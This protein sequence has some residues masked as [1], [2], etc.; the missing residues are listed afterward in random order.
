LKAQTR[1][2]TTTMMMVMMIITMVMS[3]GWDYGLQ[4]ANYSPPSWYSWITV[5]KWW[6]EE[7]SWL[8]HQSSLAILPAETYGSRKEEWAK[9]M[10]I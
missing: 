2:V 1:Y 8:V 6:T 9:G 4:R 3:M 7:N 10:R 5:V